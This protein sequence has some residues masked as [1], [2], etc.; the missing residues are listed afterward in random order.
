MK[1]HGFY[2][3]VVAL[4]IASAGGCRRANVSEVKETGPVKFKN[5]TSI[6]LPMPTDEKSAAYLG[7]TGS[8]KDFALTDVKADILFVQLFDKYCQ[9]C[10]KDAPNVNRLYERVQTSNLKDR[11]RFVG[12]GKG[13]SELEARIYKNEYQV[14]FPLFP[15]LDKGNTQRLG[16][17]HTPYFVVA[18]MKRK[19]VVHQQW[20]LSSV[21][22][23]LVKLG[24]KDGEMATGIAPKEAPIIKKDLI[25]QVKKLKPVDSKLVVKIG[26]E[27]P[28]FTLPAIDGKK[29]G[30]S[31]YRDK[32][33]VVI[34]F[35]PAAWTPVCS[36]QWPGYNIARELFERR[37]TVLLGITTDNV[38][39]L[40]AWTKNMGVMWFP[41][42][43]DFW[44]HGEV[45]KQFGVLRSDGTTER[46]L[47]VIDRKGV[48][49]WID[50][51]DINER[52][53]LDEL[54]KAL[55]DLD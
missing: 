38:P 3:V 24:G 32:K 5:L 6:R 2:I 19:G 31:D 45:A 34:S 17:D 14:P 7:V 15:D 28:D 23:I 1:R 13:N 27:A 53:V 22:E 18:D 55:D 44:P 4:A 16:E 25:Y 51:H 54:I 11:V 48:I 42:L 12:I 26:M 37:D 30:L 52:P 29:V 8:G 9:N 10:Q 33:N 20:R 50:V 43:S 35:V 39:T 41:V 40:H 21:D 47:V 49:R 46:A 36:G